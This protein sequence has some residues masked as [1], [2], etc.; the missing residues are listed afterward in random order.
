VGAPKTYYMGTTGG[1]LWTTDEMGITG[2]MSRMVI[3]RPVPLV[4]SCAAKRQNVFMRL[5]EENMAV[6]RG[7]MTTRGRRC[8]YTSQT[9][10]GKKTWKKIDGLELTQHYLA[11]V[12]NPKRHQYSKGGGT[13]GLYSHSQAERTV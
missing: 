2:G 5:G 9:T 7:V 1:G 13:G 10:R 3:L 12:I 8:M 6:L 4:L 11:P